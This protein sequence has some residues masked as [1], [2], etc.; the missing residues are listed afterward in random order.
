VSLVLA[1]ALAIGAVASI[2]G[3]LPELRHESTRDY[4]ENVAAVSTLEPNLVLYDGPV[5]PEMML[6]IFGQHAMAS[7]ALRGLGVRFDQPAEDLR[8]LDATG[9]PR[10]IG[11]V[12]TVPGKPA[13]VQGCGYPVGP[14]TTR[15]PLASRAE[16][17]R[18]VVQLGY[19][20][21][22]PA[23]GTVSTPTRDF[24]VRFEAGL[25]LLSVVADGPFSDILVNAEGPVCV[26]NALVGLPIPHPN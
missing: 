7:N 22:F 1:A 23:N 2:R 5:P 16:G 21:Q 3:A 25:H 11:L 15:V 4:V 6:P 18:L 14:R 10:K 26:T 8:M 9:T 19:Y 24:R 12:A 13:P 20:A 17:S